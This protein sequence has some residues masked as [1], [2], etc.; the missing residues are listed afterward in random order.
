[1]VGHAKFFSFTASPNTPH[2]ASIDS[3][4]RYFATYGLKALL[5]HVL[6]TYDVKVEEGKELP[7]G[8]FVGPSHIPESANLLFRKRQKQM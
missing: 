3:P 5:A 2:H 6:V 1:M 8:R 4:G 7:R